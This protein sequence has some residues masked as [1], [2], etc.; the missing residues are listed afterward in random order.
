MR[1]AFSVQHQGGGF[2]EIVDGAE[3]GEVVDA[4]VEEEAGG[5][6]SGAGG[7]EVEVG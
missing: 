4:V 2:F 1:H 3:E 6:V 7:G 5:F